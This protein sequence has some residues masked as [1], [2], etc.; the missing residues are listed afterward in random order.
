MFFLEHI[1]LIPLFPAFGAACMFFF[2][3]KLSK[4]GGERHLRRRH[5]AGVSCGPAARS[6]ST[7]ATPP[8]IPASPSR[9]CCTPGS[10]PATPRCAS[11][12][13]HARRPHRAVPRRCRLPARSAVHHL[14]AVRD[15]RGHA[16]PHLFD[17]LH[18][19]RGRLLP[20]LRL[21]EPVHVLH[22][23]AHPGQQLCGD[24]RGLGGRG[25]VLVPADRLLF[26][27]ALGVDRRQQGIHRQ[28]R[29]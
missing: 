1:W 20:L 25:P 27:A 15:R 8:P 12:L 9:R 3:R 6:G 5:C 17:G 2:G 23:D 4:S 22:A 19:A 10:A 16:H 13:H 21:P 18:G 14:A 11:T 26:P 29:G 24:V 7:R 28:P